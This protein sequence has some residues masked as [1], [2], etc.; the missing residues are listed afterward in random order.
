MKL[1]LGVIM[2]SNL[3]LRSSVSPVTALVVSLVVLLGFGISSFAADHTKDS[4]DTVK[5][6]L[7]EKKAVIVDVREED[8]W[9]EGHL[10]QAIHL[11]LSKIEKGL[12]AEELNKLFPKKTIVYTHC[13]AGVRSAKA[14]KLLNEKLPDIRALK[15][16]YGA[17]KKAGFPVTE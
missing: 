1:V 7:D 17:L 12:S 9:D 3:A 13:A 10:K 4:L 5:K 15:P 14:A 11:P 8:E 2:P 6:N 16:G